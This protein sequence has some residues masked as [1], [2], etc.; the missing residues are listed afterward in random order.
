MGH[1][2][3][4]IT[5]RRYIHLFDKQRTD[6]AVRQAMAWAEMCAGNGNIG[7]NEAG[8]PHGVERTQLSFSRLRSGYD[9]RRAA[10]TACEGDDGDQANDRRP[11]S[12]GDACNPHLSQRT[13]I[14]L[15]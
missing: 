11:P 2:S 10:C 5:E 8:K 12:A 15:R 6:D 14:H 4:S 7:K 1:E 9:L 13:H 3:S